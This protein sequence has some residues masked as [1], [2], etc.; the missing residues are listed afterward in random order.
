MHS[1]AQHNPK[2][3]LTDDDVEA[4]STLYPD[5]SIISHSRNNCI[6][7]YHNIGFVRIIVYFLVPTIIALVTIIVIQT[8]VHAYQRRELTR[9][10]DQAKDTKEALM[11]AQV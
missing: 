2:P 10:K 3:C 5:C 11:A 4:L 7:A 1:Y 6:T 8:W 9:T